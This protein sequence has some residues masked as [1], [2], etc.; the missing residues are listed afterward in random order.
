M[1][2]FAHKHAKKKRTTKK[3]EPSKKLVAQVKKIVNTKVAETKINYQYGINVG[4]PA[5]WSNSGTW[6]GHLPLRAIGQGV[7]DDDR[8]GDRIFVKGISYQFRIHRIDLPSNGSP[9]AYPLRIRFL[10]YKKPFDGSLLPAFS[11]FTSGTIAPAV[12]GGEPAG[13]FETIDKE[14]N[15]VLK[16][17]VRVSQGELYSATAWSK[18]PEIVYKL[19]IPINKTIQ[20]N[21][22]E[23]ASTKGW[24]YYVGYKIDGDPI[25]TASTAT[26]YGGYADCKVY[27]TDV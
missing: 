11:Q 2:K 21:G 10:V 22:D 5:L 4:T 27:Y 26:K 7:G 18:A 16:D 8:I 9:G 24:N 12:K 19:W 17:T 13:V 20:F 15:V 25:D 23:S 6:Y 14:K 3:S 1:V